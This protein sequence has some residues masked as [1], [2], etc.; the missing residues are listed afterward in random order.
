V[1]RSSNNLASALA[2]RLSLVS[3]AAALLLL[4]ATGAQAGGDPPWRL[5]ADLRTQLADAER[6]L[7]VGERGEAADR[8]AK[9]SPAAARLAGLLHDE[10]LAYAFREAEAAVAAGDEVRLAS[11]RATVETDVL[12]AA[13]A[14]VVERLGRGDVAAAKRW[15][16]VRE[17]RAPTRFSRPGA[18]ATLAVAA[19]A[20]G[21]GTR[22]DA[23]AAVRADLL[24]TYQARL[25]AALQAGDEALEQRFRSGLAA[26]A[27]LAR[28]YFAILAESFVGQRGADDGR[29]VEAALDRLVEAALAFRPSAYRQ[30]RTEITRELQGFRAA[31]LS[32]EV[33]IRRAGQFL[34]FLTLVPVEYGRGVAGGRVALA[35][36]VQ[37]AVTFRD[38]AAQAFADLEGPLLRRDSE[39]TRRIG[40]LVAALGHDLAGAVHGR[41]VAPEA[42]VQG[43]A[44]EALDLAKRTFPEEWKEAGEAADFDVI[45]TSLDRVVG[46]LRAGEYSRAEAARLEAYAFFEFGPEQRLRGLAPELFART[47][48]LFWYGADGLP[49]LAQIVRRKASVEEATTTRKALDAALADSEAAVGAGPTSRAAVVTNTAII[50]FREGLEAVL[51]LAALTAGLVGARRRLRRPLLVGAGMA[52]LAS[53]ATFVVAETLLSSL[54]RYGEKLE[55]VVSLI[56]IA[57]L[58]LILNWFF[59][60]IYWSDHLAGLHG[61]KKQILKGAGLSVAAAQLAGLATLGFSSV[62]REGFETVLFL[63]AF[64]LEAGAA[65]VAE[66]V[67]VGLVG[68]A[69]VGVLTISLQRKLPH[70]RMLELTGLLILGVLVVMAGKTVQVCQVVGWLPVHPIADV[71]LP[72]WA[73]LWFGVFSTWEGVAAQL[74]AAGFVLGSYSGAEWMRARRRRVRLAA[75]PAREARIASGRGDLGEALAERARL[76]ETNA[77]RG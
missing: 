35:F 52:L 9:A 49:G 51:I 55:A 23:L 50:V 62:Y 16:L 13:Y 10:S 57:V 19:L 53:V 46:A 71:R 25:L 6:A 31:P 21:R 47:E 63:Q 60:R 29:R 5:A 4:L 54:V 34:R 14:E 7:I 27:A 17:F 72:Y 69:A 20:E 67:L 48:G 15:L 36:E 24:D 2:R 59:H 42:T 18:D 65:N 33:A 70:R 38:G 61:R 1:S 12:S 76:F 56:A 3:L 39:A 8:V 22:S 44:D 73:G 26:Q 58:L 41:E 11:A 30:A 74:G 32:R 43:E 37:E 77:G 68:V 75:I 66:G 45:R 64:A 40:E 28:G